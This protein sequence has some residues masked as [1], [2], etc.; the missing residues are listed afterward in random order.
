[1]DDASNFLPLYLRFLRGVIDTNDLPLNVS[2]EILQSNPLVDTIKK[3][4]TKRTLDS[5][6]KLKDDSYEEYLEFWK[7]FGLVL[8]EGPAEDIE[9][10]ELIASLMLF[11][12]LLYTS[13]SPRDTA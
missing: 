3:S 10:R 8:K 2:R 6:K 13:P 12:C 7:E 11:N 9:N 4:I 1:M 5:L